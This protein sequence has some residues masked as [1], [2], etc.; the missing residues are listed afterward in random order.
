MP[1]K[2]TE[3]NKRAK[4]RGISFIE[5]LIALVL[6]SLTI[7]TFLQV[8][9]PQAGR[10]HQTQV[11]LAT[12]LALSHLDRLQFDSDLMSHVEIDHDT[13]WRTSVE[14]VYISE[15]GLVAKVTVTIASNER[16]L[17]EETRTMLFANE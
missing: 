3:F 11:L 2:S 14:V 13:G 5:I 16:I 15:D 7:P 1:F 12:D 6:L 17:A 8:A 10:K 9:F 4:N